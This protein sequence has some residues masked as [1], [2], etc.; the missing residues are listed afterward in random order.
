[1]VLSFHSCTLQ[2]SHNST[3]REQCALTNHYLFS[4][5]TEQDTHFVNPLTDRYSHQFGEFLYHKSTL[6]GRISQE[7]MSSSSAQ[8]LG[9]SEQTQ[10]S[11]Q[12]S[13]GRALAVDEGWEGREGLTHRGDISSVMHDHT[14]QPVGFELETQ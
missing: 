7:V 14:S 4:P 8:L 9:R 11:L 1:M 5:S 12:S 6:T 3:D 13:Y 10:V 2:H